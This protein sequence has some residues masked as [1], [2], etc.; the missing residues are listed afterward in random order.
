MSQDRT[1][2]PQYSCS[3]FIAVQL[4]S[5][6]SES[7]FIAVHSAGMV[8][9]LADVCEDRLLEDIISEEPDLIGI[10]TV[11]RPKVAWKQDEAGS[12]KPALPLFYLAQQSSSSVEEVAAVS[13]GQLH[14]HLDAFLDRSTVVRC[15]LKGGRFLQFEIPPS[16]RARSTGKYKFFKLSPSGLR[17]SCL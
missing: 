8:Q 16:D 3:V 17:V 11:T 13:P 5:P 7:V 9:V 12:S 4:V 6:V 15:D 10:P 14:R 2:F 1:W